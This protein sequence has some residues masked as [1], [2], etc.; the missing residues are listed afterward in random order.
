MSHS[1]INIT[2][3][4]LNNEHGK[5]INSYIIDKRINFKQKKNYNYHSYDIINNDSNLDINNILKS[6]YQIMIIISIEEFNNMINLFY[7]T[8]NL[9]IN[10]NNKYFILEIK[11]H[12]TFKTNMIN[13]LKLQN[14]FIQKCIS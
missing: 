9:L 10:Y 14:N 8:D 2:I 6:S 12:L 11:P 13:I 7:N 5:L 4:V 3:T 1:F